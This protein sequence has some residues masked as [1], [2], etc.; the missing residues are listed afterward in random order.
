MRE[1]PAITHEPAVFLAGITMRLAAPGCGETGEAEDLIVGI[2]T[3]VTM[4]LV[5]AGF[6]TIVGDIGA[7]HGTAEALTGFIIDGIGF[8]LLLRIPLQFALK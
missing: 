1:T 2:A 7:T 8:R 4:L 3:G 6:E 5:N